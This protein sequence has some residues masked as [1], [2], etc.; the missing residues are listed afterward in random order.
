MKQYKRERGL[1]LVALVVTII[2]L[3]ILAG[4]TLG[5]VINN[6]GVINQAKSATTLYK[7]GALSELVGT[8]VASLQADYIN[9]NEINSFKDFAILERFEEALDDNYLTLK[10]ECDNENFKWGIFQ[11][12]DNGAVYY[13]EL[14][15]NI[16]EISELIETNEEKTIREALE[17]V[18]GDY[19]LEA[20]NEALKIGMITDFS[21]NGEE[22][23]NFI[24]HINDSVYEGSFHKIFVKLFEID[25]N[26]H[27]YDWTGCTECSY[28]NPHIISSK[29]DFD[30][31]RTHINNTIDKENGEVTSTYIDGYFKLE[32]N[33]VFSEEDFEESGDFYNYNER[34]STGDGFIPIGMK[35]GPYSSLWSSSNYVYPIKLHI[36]GNNCEIKNLQIHTSEGQRDFNAIFTK[37]D[38]GSSVCNLTINNAKV[39]ATTSCGV[40][41]RTLASGS[42]INNINIINCN[43]LATKSMGNMKSSGLLSGYVETTVNNV[44]IKASSIDSLSWYGS[45]LGQI[46]GS[47]VINNVNAIDCNVKTY[48]DAGMIS[49][50]FSGSPTINNLTIEGGSFDNYSS[51][52]SRIAIITNSSSGGV[53]TFNTLKINNAKLLNRFYGLVGSTNGTYSTCIRLVNSNIDILLNNF[54]PP[55]E[56]YLILENSTVNWVN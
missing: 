5:L 3:L 21:P 28:D 13:C 20:I 17:I 4:I 37:F 51:G 46:G 41:A 38:S 42:S 8:T 49:S 6:K 26:N 48:V 12:K 18:N 43:V 22:D 33:I 50:S 31:I 19:S 10:I 23:A 16:Y 40:I 1:T 45:L 27:N 34:T 35:D 54:Q 53:L 2:I 36:D 24:Y 30:Q 14:V 47:A 55:L 44:N 25:N 52:N 32:N 56:E 15:N 7:N 9:Q 39:V 11:K 29:Y